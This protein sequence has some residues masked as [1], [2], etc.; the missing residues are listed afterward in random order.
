MSRFASW[1]CLGVAVLA[2][3]C[4]PTPEPYV[5]PVDT[6]VD[7]PDVTPPTF[8]GIK[9]LGAPDDSHLQVSWLPATDDMSPPGGISYEVYVST[10][11]GAYDFAHPTAVTA[12]GATG[13][14]IA[15]V[16]SAS[17]YSVVV[18]AFDLAGNHDNNVVHLEISTSDKTPPDFDGVQSVIGVDKSTLQLSWNPAH[19]NASPPATIKY[20]VYM[21]TTAD[22]AD[23]TAVKT[24]TPPGATSVKIDGLL[25][26]TTYWFVVRAIDEAGNLSTTTK[27]LSGTT[28]D[29]TPPTFAGLTGATASG[30]AATFTWDAA[31]DNVDKPATI[32][33]AI[34][35]AKKPG[36]EDFTKPPT[37]TIKGA[38]TLTATALTPSTKL[39]FVARARDTAG[40]YDANKVEL[41][42]TT[43]SSADVTPPTFGGLV[44]AAPSGTTTIDLAWGEASDDFSLP[45]TI[46]YE[47][48]M[49]TTP[50]GED[51]TKPPAFKLVGTTTFTV[52]GLKT[53]TPYFFVVRARDEAGNRDTNTIE[54][55]ATTL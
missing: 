48:F 17:T 44:S 28:L 45:S 1:A 32:T 49:S 51:F 10:T 33:Y 13:A 42:V 38:T 22:G 16:S 34:F 35:V 29:Q 39:F 43:G 18:R 50:G 27:V 4:N 36:A 52:T 15:G 14:I 54:K 19:D 53:K 23:L 7:V 31:T 46:T 41:S 55:T 12:G 25:E 11:V 21:A 47:I 8:A 30:T 9:G 40:N 3:H 26:A 24:I 20:A 6:G 37:Y 2:L 5:P